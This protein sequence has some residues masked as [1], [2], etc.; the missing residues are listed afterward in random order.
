MTHRRPDSGADHAATGAA[1][2][3]PGEPQR[4]GDSL[5]RVLQGL[6]AP[7]AAVLAR[8]TREWPGVVGAEVAEHAWVV[9][10]EGDRLVIGVD[11]PAYVTHFRFLAPGVR[12]WLDDVVGAG[13]I[14]AVD[15][16][17]RSR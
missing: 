1:D 13:A 8:L 9:G 2:D 12:E 5:D 15:V 7:P 6:G 11:E 17:V 3:G 14:R 16:A 4:L 10:V